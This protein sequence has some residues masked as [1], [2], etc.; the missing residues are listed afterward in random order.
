MWSGFHGKKL[1]TRKELGDAGIQ[2]IPV[3]Q[4]HPESLCVSNLTS[5]MKILG[6]VYHT[7]WFSGRSR[8]RLSLYL[9]LTIT[10]KI[11]KNQIQLYA[12]SPHKKGSL[13][14]QHM[15]EKRGVSLFPVIVGHGHPVLKVDFGRYGDLQYKLLRSTIHPHLTEISSKREPRFR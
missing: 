14:H 10:K 12:R 4:P 13:L 2:D 1:N 11:S 15:S 8:Y 3:P 5:K 7:K 9:D 6:Q